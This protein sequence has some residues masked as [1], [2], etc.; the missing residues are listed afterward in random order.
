M[1]APA[2]LVIF[3]L[4]T[5]FLATRRTQCFYIGDDCHKPLGLA[6]GRINNTQ[7]TANS[8][9]RKNYTL[10]GP[11]R[12]RLNR[13]GGYRAEP[14]R[15]DSSLT[16]NFEQ[17]M[18][19]TGVATQG[20]L[21][22][23]IREWVKA[24]YLGYSFG[25]GT[26]FFKERNRDVA[27]QFRGN[28]D[29]NT[30]VR[31]YVPRPAMV[32]SVH[33]IPTEW[34]NNFAIRL[35][36]Y[37]CI[38]DGNECES[39]PCQNNGSCWEKIRGYQ[40]NCTAGFN[41]THCEINID[42][43]A[44]NPCQNN[45][46]C[47]DLVNDF[48][49]TGC[50][51]GYTG[52]RCELEKDECAGNPCSNNGTCIDLFNGFY[53]NCSAG[54]N[55]SYCEIDIDEC[56]TNPCVNGTCSDLVNDFSCNCTPGFT[57][58]RC[59]IEI[60]ECSSNPCRHGGTCTDLI[61]GFTCHCPDGF[62]GPT[63]GQDTGFFLVV[64]LKLK[65]MTFTLPLT[66]ERSPLYQKTQDDV[67]NEVD[68]KLLFAEKDKFFGSA[69][70]MFSPSGRKLD[71]IAEILLR[72][73]MNST[74]HIMSVLTQKLK[75]HVGIFDTS[76]KAE[77][78]NRG[79][80][81]CSP[82]N[83][84]LPLSTGITK[85]TKMKKSEDFVFYV[86]L[87]I[88]CHIS[89]QVRVVFI[90]EIFAIDLESGSFSKVRTRIG[91]AVSDI[92]AKI[93][94]K[95]LQLW[96]LLLQNHWV[97]RK[98]YWNSDGSL[99]HDPDVGEGD[100]TGLDF[101]WLCRRRNEKFPDNITGL[102][103][104]FPQSG[105]TS[106]SGQDK[107]GCYGTGVGK[108]KPRDGFPYI[109]DLD[110]DK[111]KG[112]EDYVI[113]MAMSKRGQ[114]VFA[115]HQLRIKEEIH[116]KITCAQNCERHV[117]LSSRMI[118][119][120][121]CIGLLCNKIDFYTWSMKYREK[122]DLL[123]KEVVNL[124]EIVLTYE[125]SPNLVTAQGKLRG[126]ATYEVTVEATTP[127]GH[128][129]TAT[130]SFVTNTPPSG[131]MCTVDNPQ[132]K[133]W[134]T[135]FVFR[136]IGWHDDN[137]PLKFQFS[138]NSSDGIEMIFQSGISSTTT[139]KLPVGDPNMDY[140]LHIQILVIDSL[141]SIASTWIDVKVTEPE[142]TIE[143]LE[144][145]VSEDG[146]M[147]EYLKDNNIEMAAQR[148]TSVLS[149]VN[150]AP[151]KMIKLKDKIKIKDSIV[152]A[153]SAVNVSDLQQV[154]QVSAVV[155]SVADKRNE[156]SIESQE[157]AVAMLDSMA[158]F[159]DQEV[160]NKSNHDSEEL[161][162]HVGT[163]LLNGLGN[164]LDI[165]AH[166][167]KE[168][169]SGEDLPPIIITNERREKSKSYS[170]EILRLVN[171]VGN[172][173]DYTKELYE[174]PSV[175]KTRSLSMVLD[176][177]VPSRIGNKA[178]EYEGSKVTL[179][180][181]QELIGEDGKNKQYL[182]TQLLTFK[183]NPYTWDRGASEIKSSVLDFELKDENGYR[184]NVSNLTQEV[185]L[186][187]PPLE[188]QRVKEP[189]K[190]FVKPSDNGTMRYHKVVFPGPEYAISIKIVPS[191]KKVLTLYVRYA[192]RPTLDYSNFNASVPDYSS[193]N[194]SM[195]HKNH[196]NCST[197]PF[198][199]TLSAAVTGHTGL[200]YIG[201]VI[202]G[203][204][205]QTQN[206]ATTPGHVRRVRRDCFHNG[207]QKRSCV[208]VKDPPTTPPPITIIKPPFNASTDVNYTLSVSMGTC[209]YWNVT[210]DAWS[211]AGCRVGPKSTP[212]ATQCLCNH[213]SSFGGN[214]FVAPNPID[215]DYVFKQFPSIFESGNVVVLATVLTI[216][217]LWI[218][219]VVIARR[220]DR[221]DE[222]K[223]V[224]NLRLHADGEHLYEVSVY[225]GMWKGSGTSA[226][227]AMIVY[228]EETRSETL[229]LFDTY[230]NKMLF[231]RAS[232]NNFI[233]SLPDNLHSPIMIKLWHDNSGDN[234]S[235]Y[236]NQVVIKD[237]E[238]EEKW[239]FLCSRWLAVDKEDG[240]VEVDIPLASKSDLSSFK[241][242]FYTRVS[243]SLGDGHIW[244]SVVTRPPHSPFTRAQR[245]SCCICV[246]LCAMLAGAMFY[247]F[248]EKQEDT[249]KFGPLRFS[250]KQL[251]IGVQSAVIVVPLN[252]L[253]V[254]IFRNIKLPYSNNQ[255]PHHEDEESGG[256]VADSPKKKKVR[257]PGC[258]P[259][260]F[261]YIG[262]LLCIL[263][264]LV[265]GTIVVFYSVQWGKEISNQWLT[266]AL[267]SFFQDVALMQPIKVIA[268]ALLLALILK[269]PPEEKTA[270]SAKDSALDVNKN[271]DVVAPTGEEL[272]EARKY[273][274]NIVETISNLV[275][276]LLFLVFVVCL[277]VIVYGNRGYSRYRLTS[278]LENMFKESFE[279]ID[280]K[281][282]FWEWIEEEFIP[283]VY[284]TSWYNGQ[285]FIAPEGYISSRESFLVG[286][287]RFKQVRVR[288]EYPCEV[289]TKYKPME[290][291]FKRC[292][293]AY[294]SHDEDTTRFNLPGWIPVTNISK[295]HSVYDLLRLCPKPW[296]YNTSLELD[297]LS[298]YG[299]H[300]R[301]D[302]GGYVADLGYDSRTASRVVIN[303]ASND[304]ID[305]RTAAVF[306]EFT[307]FQPSTSL[308]TVAKFL[309]EVYPTGQPVCRA[310]FDT[311][312]I[313]GSSDPSLRSLFVACQIILLLLIAY[314]LLLEVVKIYR[315]SCSY[316][317][318]FWNW[319]NLLQLI[320][321]II[322]VAF[323]FFKEKYVSS[324]VQQVQ[325][326]PFE[327]ASADYVLFWS[328]LELIVLSV[329]VFIVT[330]KFLRI[331]RFNR[332]V[333]QM[334]SSLKLSL[335]HITSYSAVFFV[336]ILSFTMLG[337]LVFGN[338]LE[339]YHTFVEALV[340]L[341]QKFL[342]GDLY[343]YEIQSSNRI[344]GPLFVFGYMLS[345]TF[346]LINMFVAI[347][348]ESYESVRE[349]SGGK[350]ADAELGNFI[351]QYYLARLQR[352]HEVAKRRLANF[353][354]RHKLYDRPKNEK[355]IKLREEYVGSFMSL[356]SDYP[357]YVEPLDWPDNS[358]QIGL[359]DNEVTI[360]GTESSPYSA[361]N[362]PL[363]EELAELSTD[364][365]D[366]T[367]APSLPS[368]DDCSVEL[369]D[370]LGDLPVSVVAPS[371]ASSSSCSNAEF[372]NLL[373]DLPES[374]VDDDETVD[375]V[376]KRLADVGAVLRLDKRTLRRFSTTGDKYIVQTN[377][378]MG[379]SVALNFRSRRESTE[380]DVITD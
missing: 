235:W 312:S 355:K 167:A 210:V 344:L 358:S 261:V 376:R 262:W 79:D 248:G 203:R 233:V 288:A 100:Y 198:T 375:N 285:R 151:R 304:W 329:V 193:C 290:G 25:S 208:G 360:S 121:S 136:C 218:I 223:A 356:P 226:N 281:D 318:S 163:A 311:L 64:W 160:N 251:V 33:I 45:G 115:V 189:E 19:I 370:L 32:K 287:P 124:D 297:T 72:T 91:T 237:L 229:R 70:R 325:A 133:A 27:K 302:G 46:S 176:R 313:Y 131:G 129:S 132:G 15:N 200:H 278:N 48:K 40:C 319:M 69:L 155:A 150:H 315:Q 256:N 317:G 80:L 81:S 127:Q 29:N 170:K 228:G 119:E 123:W 28:R 23:N 316:F 142:I 146:P 277:F 52:K 147:N 348:N 280:S 110:V 272:L 171:R 308:F 108:L 168:D 335:P 334:V 85:A 207:R 130:Y 366:T 259:H 197:D 271:V 152:D 42:D 60:N 300:T 175:L 215:F 143:S 24:Y 322:T 205:N 144:K 238:T 21:G 293:P 186:F 20:Y 67:I 3:A 10:Y 291:M 343:F 342:G 26:F 365:P 153:W 275:E 216:F 380:T 77:F 289:A 4:N 351:K 125:N 338:D 51:A 240:N 138:Y 373:G 234:P 66:N 7:I 244:L 250:L 103:I 326:N 372:L 47:V 84:S 97:Y 117:I 95:A 185:E 159:M 126:N 82:P 346:I 327:T 180:S 299:R 209:Q 364:E 44:S 339:S 63:C 347:L 211:T 120:T 89:G 154:S 96:L 276:I 321:A 307:I 266:S 90:E 118:L 305:E 267:I 68:D 74:N 227:V 323:F 212:E 274:E 41:G 268:V 114:T 379:P 264:S 247:Q 252:L 349:L 249:V 16:V 231:A 328:D 232:I 174:K 254:A 122:D 157:K 137:L 374:M 225:T 314:F 191:G 345:M 296:R 263:A 245:L 320:S 61:N 224:E 239:Y 286:M 298:Y 332:H 213:L 18:I 169:I 162:E 310:R 109:V 86:K 350:F 6:D 190:Y 195:E 340:T 104:V 149:V 36:L 39:F 378:H 65:N 75:S 202:G 292:I 116:L 9:Y 367:S 57:G 221:K 59:N 282:A 331:I 184:L 194:F 294:S 62:G 270:Q 172:N 139:G 309:Y 58:K 295:Y 158:N 31:H 196:T 113:K 273:R 135:D 206:N 324:F 128:S 17:P 161:I 49:C 165:T 2:C 217:G 37:G 140:K 156:L 230:S 179:P 377:F 181:T 283:G 260:F 219:G 102:P 199:V 141:G 99:S 98:T 111:M 101:T 177:Q 94:G 301:Y 106:L 352:L 30:I 330:V 337:V 246:L 188:K 222:Y 76:Y 359:I 43:C 71:V 50:M 362:I 164:L 201:I 361:D 34:E 204:V 242:Q 306:V 183:S 148:A 241:Y 1:R 253:I 14:R 73:L 369:L 8:V 336:N 353:G 284:D 257:S 363:K 105:S 173:V 107:G 236:V 182:S 354:F 92:K 178:L 341:I 35:E 265:A 78:E 83:I 214:F 243:K 192:E 134:E 5:V 87:A 220:A 56:S 187:I 93:S 371:F 368:S 112:D 279:E 145:V 53:C 357:P 333:C 38:A 303:L 55:G 11:S 166:E 12:A 269:K 22:G 258:L 255:D 54:F 13:T 88:N